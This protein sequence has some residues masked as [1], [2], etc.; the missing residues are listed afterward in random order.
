MFT[1]D[2]S[3]QIKTIILFFLIVL[4]V[5]VSLFCCVFIVLFCGETFVLIS[6][7]GVFFVCGLFFLFFVCVFFFFFFFFF[8]GGGAKVGFIL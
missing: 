1:T 6:F 7:G 8:W 4:C 3:E 5:C 2:T